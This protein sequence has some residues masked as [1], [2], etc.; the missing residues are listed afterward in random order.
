MIFMAYQS[1]CFFSFR[2][3]SKNH[4]DLYYVKFP[5][6]WRPSSAKSFYGESESGL[7]NCFDDCGIGKARKNK[8][9]NS[10]AYL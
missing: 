4:G 5:S 2:R 7:E 9:F 3:S 1:P 10:Q 6:F 8:P